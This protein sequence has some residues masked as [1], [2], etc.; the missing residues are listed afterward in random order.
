MVQRSAEVR[1]GAGTRE[2]REAGSQE[3]D[4]LHICLPLDKGV[5]AGS[6]GKLE[7]QVELAASAQSQQHLRRVLEP[8]MQESNSGQQTLSSVRRSDGTR[9]AMSDTHCPSGV[10]AAPAS[11]CRERVQRGR[12]IRSQLSEEG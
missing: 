3:A 5:D 9:A 10:G 7:H 1:S 2:R 4:R 11:A 12:A 8:A 6:A